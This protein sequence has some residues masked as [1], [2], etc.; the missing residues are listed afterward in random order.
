MANFSV[1][2]WIIVSSMTRRDLHALP[3]ARILFHNARRIC[4]R[5]GGAEGLAGLSFLFFS[6]IPKYLF[7]SLRLVVSGQ[8]WQISTFSSHLR[9]WGGP[10]MS[11]MSC[12]NTL[13]QTYLL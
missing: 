12:W 3:Q 5:Y 2:H 8:R 13:N 11:V 1:V 10:R 6:I 4:F 9:L 7:N